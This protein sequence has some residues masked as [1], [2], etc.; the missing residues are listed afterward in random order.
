MGQLMGWRRRR[1]GDGESADDRAAFWPVDQ[2]DIDRFPTA[3]ADLIRL[4]G[5]G[6][7]INV[8]VRLSGEEQPV[9]TTA[10][11][12]QA[13]ETCVLVESVV[14]RRIDAGEPLDPEVE[15]L[16]AEIAAWRAEFLDG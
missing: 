1:E 3:G 8:S 5:D 2:A 14:R 9:P 4:T 7:V 11:W 6:G 13:A 12:D 15:P 10:P 16:L